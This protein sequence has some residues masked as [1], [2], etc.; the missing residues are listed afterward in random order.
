MK[1][2]AIAKTHIELYPLLSSIT[3]ATDLISR[4][5]VDHHKKISFVAAT[6]GKALG[7][8]QH[9]LERLI[10]A[11]AVHDIGGLSMSIRVKHSN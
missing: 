1:P 10:L 5:L 3:A 9:S 4:V 6:I 11:A 2:E 8:D 7:L